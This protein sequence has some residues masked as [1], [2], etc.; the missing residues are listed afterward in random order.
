M[1]EAMLLIVGRWGAGYLG[2]GNAA[3]SQETGCRGLGGGNALRQQ[4][5]RR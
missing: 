5:G 1:V 4:A 3:S 2:R